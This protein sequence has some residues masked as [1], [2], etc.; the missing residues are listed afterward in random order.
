MDVEDEGGEVA[1]G[2]LGSFLVLVDL[3]GARLLVGLVGIVLIEL[4][5][6]RGGNVDATDIE[7]EVA[8]QHVD[9]TVGLGFVGLLSVLVD[10]MEALGQ[11]LS[12]GAVAGA[13]HVDHLVEDTV[14]LRIA[15]RLAV[16]QAVQAVIGRF[17]KVDGSA[18][19][20]TTLVVFAVHHR[21]VCVVEER[22]YTQALCAAKARGNI[23]Q[24]EAWI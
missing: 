11:C 22:V 24:S 8:V 4:D 21:T 16:E 14:V 19:F 23:I 1:S 17:S 18:C 12:V 6:G 15:T 7:Q 10:A 9:Q 5:I 3:V 20:N 13:G 2:T